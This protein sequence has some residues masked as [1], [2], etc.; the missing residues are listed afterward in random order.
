MSIS[1]M[2]PLLI[3]SGEP[4]GIGPDLC[5]ALANYTFPVVILGDKSLLMERA[6][7][8]K[9]TIQFIDYYPNLDVAL[10]EGQ[11]AILDRPCAAPVVAGTLDVR[12]APYVIEMLTLATK[13]CLAGEFSALITAPVH[14]SILNEAG[15]RFT[16]HTEF[17]AEQ[18]QVSTVVML[19]VSENLKV[20]LVT[21][22]LP[23]RA[24]PDAISKGLIMDVI[25]TLNTGLQTNFGIAAPSLGVAGLNPHAGEGGHLGKEEIAVI[26]PALREL[27]MR[28]LKVQGPF[29]ADTLFTPKYLDQFDAFVA[30][31]HDQ[32]LPVLKYAG[33]GSAVNVT[34]GLPIIR[35]SVDHGTALDLAGKSLANPNSL[36]TAVKMAASMVHHRYIDTGAESSW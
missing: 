15:Y 20:A 25:N 2:K 22:H 11:L 12:N 36:L 5:L 1:T 34:L 14:K 30:M 35:T 31:Y 29:P 21:T 27:K 33:F 24:V 32:G 10:P 26:Q 6:A 23:L 7:L 8:L 4:A 28:G 17:L 3:S 19:L 9:Q 16:G 13:Q 18:C